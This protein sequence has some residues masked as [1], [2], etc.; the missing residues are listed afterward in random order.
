MCMKYI[1]AITTPYAS[2][3]VVDGAIV[4]LH[5]PLQVV[6]GVVL[7]DGQYYLSG[8]DVV[9]DLTFLGTAKEENYISNPVMNGDTIDIIL[10][11]TRCAVDIEERYYIDLDR[12]SVDLTKIRESGQMKHACFDYYNHTQVTKVPGK[13]IKLPV[14]KEGRALFGLYALKVIVEQRGGE[15]KGTVQTISPLKIIPTSLESQSDETVGDALGKL[16]SK[17]W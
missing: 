14:D 11:L 5:A 12:F 10:R 9:T 2:A 4:S 17:Q 13:T 6:R 1:N 3:I 8:F 16:A 15:D 7:E